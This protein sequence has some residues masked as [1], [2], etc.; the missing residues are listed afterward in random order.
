MKD[1]AIERLK[2]PTL[3]E[4]TNHIG[5]FNAIGMAEL[6]KAVTGESW[7]NRI[8][9]TRA[10]RRVITALRREGVPICSSAAQ[11]GGGY[12]LAAA[13]S[14]LNGYLR[15][16]KL[17]ALKILARNAKIQKT[18]LPNYLGQLRLEM[19]GGDDKEAAG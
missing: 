8:N 16:Q 15:R 7:D 13:G 17:R 10:I 4:L 9:D 12:Y 3:A 6:Y 11:N 1:K 19:E 5:E 18:S 2:T 14:E